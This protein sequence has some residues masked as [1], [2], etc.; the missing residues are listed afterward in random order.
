M[1][2]KKARHIEVSSQ[3]SAGSIYSSQTLLTWVIEF[4]WWTPPYGRKG[5]NQQFNRLLEASGCTDLV[6]L[7]QLPIKELVKAGDKSHVDARHAQE[8]ASGLFYWGPTIDG[9]IIQDFPLKEFENG[10]FSK[11]P[12]LTNRNKF[13]GIMFTNFSLKTTGDVLDD[14]ATTWPNKPTEKLME[15]YPSSIYNGAMLQDIPFMSLIKLIKRVNTLVEIMTGKTILADAVVQRQS[16]FGDVLINC[17]SNYMA[18][19]VSAAGLNAYKM[20]F[21]AGI[22]IHGAIA[23][24]A[25]G[26]KTSGK[27]VISM[28]VQEKH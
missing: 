4:P 7:R 16:F 19:G 27:L 10:H 28:S 13:E 11:V 17:P 9:V 21:N 8:L 20:I 3:V 26:Q 2:V 6:C 25:Y 5:L 24:Y 14:L 1:G 23:V 12:L 22:Q 15:L 18:K